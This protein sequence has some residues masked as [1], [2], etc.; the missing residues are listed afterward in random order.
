MADKLRVQFQFKEEV[1][2]YEVYQVSTYG[3]LNR[4]EI[5]LEN[6]V[7]YSYPLNEIEMANIIPMEMP[8]EKDDLSEVDYRGDLPYD[9]L[10]PDVNDADMCGD[11]EEVGLTD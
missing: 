11:R 5:L 2:G 7:I 10:D 8:W 9:L 3:H 6:G 4:F 1:H